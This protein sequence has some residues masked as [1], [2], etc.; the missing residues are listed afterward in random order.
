VTHTGDPQAQVARLVELFEH[1][2]RG[3]V[4]RLPDYYAA[5]VRFADPFNDVR[6]VDAVQRIF[7]HMF[8][9]LDDPR[10]AVR[11]VLGSGDQCFLTWDMHFRLRRDGAPW[12]LHGASHLM[13]DANGRIVLHRDYWDAAGE[14]YER[15]P[16]LGTLMRWLKRR[17]RAAPGGP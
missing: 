10:F 3:D 2:T 1:L 13:F 8:D 9:T 5:D 17:L 15:L 11:A 6:G 7:E 16:V 14:L 4:V 12:T